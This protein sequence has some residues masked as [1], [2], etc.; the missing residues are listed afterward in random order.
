[1]RAKPGQQQIPHTARIGPVRN[2]IIGGGAVQDSDDVVGGGAV[3]VRKKPR[4]TT[5]K[6]KRVV[7]QKAVRNNVVKANDDKLTHTR[8]AHLNVIPNPSAS[9]GWC[10]GSGV[11]IFFWLYPSLSETSPR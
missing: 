4:P 3:R 7:P 6:A 9:F 1:M 2:D 5:T 11:T 8:S 10:E